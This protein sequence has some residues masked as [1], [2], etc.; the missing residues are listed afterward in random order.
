MMRFFISLCLFL[1]IVSALEL[2]TI[3]SIMQ[4]NIHKSLHILQTSKENTEVIAQK[5][6]SMFD[7]IFDWELM[8]KLALSQSYNS[9]LPEDQKLFTQ[10]FENNIKQS[11]TDKLRLY[12]N[13]A[14]EIL[15]GKLVQPNR[16][17]LTT[18]LIIDGKI[19]Y[20]IFKFYPNEK[21]DW[22]IYDV[23][24]LG[25]SIIQTYRS[26]LADI[27]KQYDFATLIQ[28]L[29]SEITLDTK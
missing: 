11:F 29:Q 23:D 21:Q 10:V 14:L 1:N 9:L 6:F 16:Y 8:A 4:Q 15:E 2:N 5:I 22:K 17:H 7:N 27:L 24:V 19:N 25:I 20:I 26:Q 3:H 18:S 13:Q 12:K 28:K